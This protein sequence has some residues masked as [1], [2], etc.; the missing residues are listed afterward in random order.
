MDHKIPI[1][2]GIN[3]INVRSYC[4]PHLLKTKIEKQVAEMLRTGIIK[5]NVRGFALTIGH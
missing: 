3:P 2:T 5:P 1:K 4:Y